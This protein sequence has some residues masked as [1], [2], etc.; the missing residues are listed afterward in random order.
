M[1]LIPEK[2]KV[3]GYTHKPFYSGCFQGIDRSKTFLFDQNH[4]EMEIA[5]APHQRC[6]LKEPGKTV[7]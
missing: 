4:G 5:G 7:E 1:D 3:A 6:Q 2:K